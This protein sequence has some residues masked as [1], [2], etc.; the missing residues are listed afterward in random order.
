MR[1]LHA[2]ASPESPAPTTTRESYRR[3]RLWKVI[4]AATPASADAWARVRTKLALRSVQVDN[5]YATLCRVWAGRRSADYGIIYLPRAIRAEGWPTNAAVHRVS[6][7]LAHGLP[8]DPNSQA[9]HL[10]HHKPCFEPDHLTWGTMAQNIDDSLKAGRIRTKLTRP[11]VDAIRTAAA[12]G[13]A[14]TVLASHYGVTYY[15]IRS[16]V[17]G[18][19]WR[20]CLTE[21]QLQDLDRQ[22]VGLAPLRERPL[23]EQILRLAPVRP[24]DEDPDR[25]ASRFVLGLAARYQIGT[26]EA[27]HSLLTGDWPA[28]GSP[29]SD[30]AIE[31]LPADAVLRLAASEGIETATA[32]RILAGR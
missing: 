19:T 3:Q 23:T 21:E 1:E 25:Y 15:T 6:C 13:I 9:R 17:R 12:G 11:Q 29:P 30:P 20:W 28:E 22:V 14:M 2:S 32:A 18:A 10:C 4:R 8:P 7:Y 24:A 27:L 16:I 26:T 31:A 5:G